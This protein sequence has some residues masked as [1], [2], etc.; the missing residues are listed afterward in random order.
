MGF[1]DEMRYQSGLVEKFE[2]NDDGGFELTYDGG[3]TLWVPAAEAN[4]FVPEVGDPVV[5]G[6]VGN[7]VAYIE[8]GLAILR[9]K[10]VE[11]IQREHNDWLAKIRADKLKR[12]AEHGDALKARAAALHPALAARMARFDAENGVEFWIEDAPYEMAVMEGADALLRKVAELDLTG[13]LAVQWIE[14]WWNINSELHDPPY[15][16]AKQMAMVPDF[17]DGHSGY[18][19]SAAKVFAVAVLQGKDV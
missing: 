2:V 7:Y 12:Y 6:Q 3:W 9:D 10:S 8:V 14:D 18:T 1:S 17:G 5:I 15:D 19:A 4:G 11:D 13:S 16:Y